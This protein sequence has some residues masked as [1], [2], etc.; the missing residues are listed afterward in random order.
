MSTFKIYDDSI[1]G[2]KYVSE[3]VYLTASDAQTE[4]DTLIQ[5]GKYIES[6][7]KHLIIHQDAGNGVYQKPDKSIT[8][9]GKI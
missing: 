7:R 8:D 4:I 6:N 2:H 9:Y 1:G 3:D 5:S